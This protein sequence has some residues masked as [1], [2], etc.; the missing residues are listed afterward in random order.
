MPGRPATIVLTSGALAVLDS[1]Q[2]DAVLAHERAHL[3]GRHHLLITLTKALSVILPAVPLFAAGSAEVARLAEMC[4]DDSAARDSGRHIVLAALL[5]MGTGRAVPAAALAA[6]AGAITTRVQRLLD[7]PPHA[8][9]ARNGAALVTVTVLLAAATG[10][11]ALL[12]GPLAAHLA[13]LT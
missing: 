4:A 13:A 8:R 5:T 12:A 1:A 11:M 6:T 3:A 9:Q 10:L 7:P 2:L